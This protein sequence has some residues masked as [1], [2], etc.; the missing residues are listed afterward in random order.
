[1]PMKERFIYGLLYN[2]ADVLVSGK[3]HSQLDFCFKLASD[4]VNTKHE[5][6]SSSFQVA[7]LKIGE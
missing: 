6:V 4:M 5:I 1:M 7:S 3:V 2:Q